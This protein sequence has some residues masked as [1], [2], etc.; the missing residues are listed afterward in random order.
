MLKITEKIIANELKQWFRKVI[1]DLKNDD[2]LHSCSYKLDKRQSYVVGLY[3]AKE[4]LSANF[5]KADVR[6]FADEKHPADLVVTREYVKFIHHYDLGRDAVFTLA[7]F[8]EDL[9]KETNH[10]YDK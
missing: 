3:T 6:A 2:R 1:A 10:R 7:H 5:E 8:S 4:K 9:F